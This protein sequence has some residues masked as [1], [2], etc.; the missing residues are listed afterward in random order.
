MSSGTR[1]LIIVE[2]LPV[3]FD[4]RVWNEA[5]ALRDAGYEVTVI[6]PVGKGSDDLHEVLDGIRIYRHPLPAESSGPLGY[7]REYGTALYH[8]FRLASRVRRLHGI[9]I[10]HLCNPPDL[11]FVVALWQ[12]LFG[13]VRVV[14]DH[15]D[16]NPELYVEKFGRRDLFY[17]LL[18]FAERLTMASANVVISTNE[19]YRQIA[20]E[21]GGKRPEDVFVVRS[22]PDT[23]HFGRLPEDPELRRWRRR[24]VGYVGV[25]A[26]QDGLDLLLQAAHHIVH[27]KQRDEVG[28]LLVGG[29]PA[30]PELVELRDRLGLQDHV[31]FA[32]F[33]TGDELLT[34]LSSCDVGVSPDPA[35]E[36][37]T[38]CTMNK[39]LEY[40]ALGLPVV[41]F[42]LREGRASAG[43]AA[44][45]A[46]DNDP[47]DMGE[48]ILELLDDEKLAKE[49]GARGRE[50]FSSQ[51]SWDRQVP[52]L[53]AA[54]RMVR[55]L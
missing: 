34:V 40:M 47:A 9:D 27:A 5:R 25:M 50:R 10:V 20:L 7:L 19:S 35:S 22:A 41:Q 18:R 30:L 53:L 48:K 43:D 37:N 12:R 49:M 33:L 17:Q 36:Y 52:N 8:E 42:D 1:V 21:R 6:C 23:A 2:N 39:T 28:F 14:F 24:L 45:Y 15:H 3:P 38:L 4:R 32:G 26:K 44:L 16:V 13:R 46:A 55:G 51:L 31:R 29:G 11:L 54:Y